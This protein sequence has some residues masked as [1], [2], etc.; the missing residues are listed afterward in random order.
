MRGSRLL[1]LWVPLI[2]PFG[3]PSPQGEKRGQIARSH[4]VVYSFCVDDAA[5]NHLQSHSPRKAI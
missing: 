1:A 2:R 3:P 5:A 4:P